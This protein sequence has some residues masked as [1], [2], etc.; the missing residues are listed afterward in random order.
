[1]LLMYANHIGFIVVA[2]SSA[3]GLTMAAVNF[4]ESIGLSSDRI[5]GQGY[6][7]ASVMS[8][9]LGGVHKLFGDHVK[10]KC[11]YELP[12]PFVPCASPNL[13]LVIINAVKTTIGRRNIFGTIED[14]YL[15][16]GPA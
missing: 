7:G 2:N 4:L 6:D 16:F 10:R 3:L 9:S 11:G 15:F 1:M 12:V 5:R 14:I 8:G 13:N